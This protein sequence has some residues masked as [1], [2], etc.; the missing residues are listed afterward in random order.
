MCGLLDQTRCYYLW[1]QAGKPV[2]SADNRRQG[3]WAPLIA[4]R[5]R[6]A[7]KGLPLANHEV[8]DYA[9]K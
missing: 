4:P 9:I 1:K 2:E 3:Q 8:T 5:K 7:Y 6:K